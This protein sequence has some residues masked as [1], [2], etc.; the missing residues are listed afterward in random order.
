MTLLPHSDIDG[1]TGG[2]QHPNIYQLFFAIFKSS[3]EFGLTFE[4]FTLGGNSGMVGFLYMNFRWLMIKTLL[5]SNQK[6]KI[7]TIDVEPFV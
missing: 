4:N 3:K 1:N 5:L 7:A 6:V 2:S